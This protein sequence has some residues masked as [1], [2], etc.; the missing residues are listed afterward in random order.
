MPDELTRYLIEHYPNAKYDL[1][2]AFLT[3]STRLLESGARLSLICQQSFL[4][5]QR[6]QNF[7]DDLNGDCDIEAI[8]LLGSGTFLAKPGEK[9]NNVIITLRKR[10]LDQ[11]TSASTL[12][13]WQMLSAGEKL[14]A[15]SVGLKNKPANI[16][17][18]SRVAKASTSAAPLLFLH[19]LEVEQLF[20][21][22]PALESDRSGVACSN[23]LFTCDNKRF[24]KHFA[25][26]PAADRHHYVPYDKGGG[27]KW[28]RTTPHLLL[29]ENDGEEIRQFRKSRGQ[30]RALPGEEYYFKPGVT[31]SYIGTRGFKARMLSPNSIFDIASSALFT[32]GLDI[33]YL[34][35]FLNSSLACYLLGILNPTINFQIGDL[36]RLPFKQPTP[37]VSY[38]VGKL[39]EQALRLAKRCEEIDPTSAAFDV[40]SSASSAKEAY[41]TYVSLSSTLSLEEQKLQTEIDH[42]ILDLYTLSGALRTNISADPWVSRS[43]QLLVKIM[44]FKRFEHSLAERNRITVPV[45]CTT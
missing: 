45:D 44:P 10:T 43:R 26:V 33:N 41:A 32:D 28:F 38:Q 12:R 39:A 24:L 8:A 37:E 27:H 30:S 17:S 42:L 20:E 25:E 9:T 35:G 6:Y 18:Y 1:Y 22:H 21:I 23:G 3:L 5:I 14:G 2:A 16:V 29:W 36:R 19:P 13:C 7:R 15:E 11:D 4:S 31:Y 40:A 34:L